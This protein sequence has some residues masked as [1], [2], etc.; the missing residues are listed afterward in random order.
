ML[1]RSI[2]IFFLTSTLLSCSG[3]V[4][5]S[6]ADGY[7]YTPPPDGQALNCAA[8]NSDPP[9]SVCEQYAVGFCR[10]LLNCSPAR[11]AWTTLDRC[12]EALKANCVS[13]Y[14]DGPVPTPTGQVWAAAQ[15]LLAEADCK[16]HNLPFDS[17]CYL[18]GTLNSGDKCQSSYDCKDGYACSTVEYGCGTCFPITSPPAGCLRNQD[19][20]LDAGALCVDAS[21]KVLHTVGQA[22]STNDDCADQ[23]FCSNGKCTFFRSVG[24]NCTADSDCVPNL[25]C[26]GKICSTL[27]EPGEG[28][29]CNIWCDLGLVCRKG[30]CAKGA[31][32]DKCQLE[33]ASQNILSACSAGLFCSVN[34]SDNSGTCIERTRLGESC[35]SPYECEQGL[36]CIMKKCHPLVVAYCSE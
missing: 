18:Q 16:F 1:T 9:L 26:V 22:C 5:D 20:N 30:T 14:L 32:G 27:V 13:M 24:E 6:T 29:P 4:S 10:G 34:T 31:V 35:T 36:F 33:D 17:S 21:C 25:T 15:R 12:V 11:F 8:H 28:K 3:K 2:P 7:S 19:C 23:T